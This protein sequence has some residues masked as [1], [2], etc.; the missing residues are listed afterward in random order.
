MKTLYERLRPEV[1]ERLEEDYEKYPATIGD[2]IDALKSKHS[3]IILTIN[4]AFQLIEHGLPFEEREY[5][6]NKPSELFI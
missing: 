6:L 4:E 5:T 1:K 2:I 3:F